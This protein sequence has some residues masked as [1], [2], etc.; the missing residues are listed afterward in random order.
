MARKLRV[1]Y[2]GAIYHVMDRGD[3]RED[4]FV[5]DADRH[6]LIRTLAEACAKTG[7]QIHA[8]CLMRNHFHL[9]VETP[10]A[11]LVDGMHWFLSTYTIRLNKRSNLSGHVFS[12]RY[13][14]IPIDGSGTG[15]AQGHSPA[16][17]PRNFKKRQCKTAPMDAS[18]RPTRAG[19]PT[20]TRHMSATE[21]DRCYGLTPSPPEQPPQSAPAR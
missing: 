15:Y 2:P 21:N 11:N 9:V 7:W 1:Q 14:A 5:D 8:D 20:P 18:S 16:A 10:N 17:S 12:G 19:W 4:I 3:R 6:D 13:K